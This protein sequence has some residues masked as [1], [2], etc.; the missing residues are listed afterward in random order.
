MQ[1]VLRN[2][3]V[4]ALCILGAC[5]LI[6]IIGFVVDVA[7]QPAL[8]KEGTR[9]LAELK[10]Y[11]K[12]VDNNAWDYYAVV[13][14]EMKNKP[15]S[16]EVG[17]YLNQE[18]D[19]KDKIKQELISYPD[20]FELIKQGNAQPE[21]WIPI[22]YEAGAFAE[23]PEYHYLI[24]AARLLGAQTVAALETG[25]M[26][27][28]LDKTVHGLQFTRH[29]L[30][31]SP[32]LMN[33][34]ISLVMLGI[35][36]HT[37]ELSLSSGGYNTRQLEQLQSVLE[38]YELDMPSL[39]TAFRLEQ[40]SMK[41]TMMNIPLHEAITQDADV[42]QGNLFHKFSERLVFWRYFF[43]PRLAILKAMKK[44]DEML[45]AA[46]QSSRDKRGI[47]EDL[48]VLESLD[49]SDPDSYGKVNI[50]FA[51]YMPQYRG[52]FTKKLT[53]QARIRM[54]LCAVLLQKHA[55]TFGNF[56][57]TLDPFDSGITQ[58]PFTKKMWEYSST[59]KEAEL[60]SPG[61]DQEYG[62]DD[63]LLVTLR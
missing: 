52:M 4:F 27:T 39:L 49:K 23:L 48:A 33:Y 25:D 54:L 45:T 55:R 6:Y 60:K 5:I 9:A 44:G 57:V 41:V 31:G 15:L 32:A 42:M 47:D 38:P 35:N 8:T 29:V 16:S 11:Q 62:T 1:K 36:L 53:S 30:H 10:T 17:R 63:D 24:Q 14:Q 59:Q 12:T 21:C 46:A 18:I 7:T 50:A 58:D 13:I 51:F 61:Y 22:Q 28:V 3:G 43:S 2:A 56:P 20:I 37:L 19:L 40:T 26:P 34:I